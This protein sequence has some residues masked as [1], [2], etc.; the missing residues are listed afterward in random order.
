MK[1][2]S[3]PKVIRP[4]ISATLAIAL[5]ACSAFQ[6]ARQNVTVNTTTPGATIKANGVT[7]GT[8]PVTFAAKRNQDLNLVATK[9]G[10]QAS[11]MQV[12]RQTSNTFALDL[13]GGW[14]FLLPWIGLLTPGAYELSNTQVEMPMNKAN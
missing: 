1:K 7:V 10:Y 11:V 5:S 2:L 6:P 9:P 8:S 13:I 3:H 14:F 4:T 12:S